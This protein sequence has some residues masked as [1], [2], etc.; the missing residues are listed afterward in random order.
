[1]TSPTFITVNPSDGNPPRS[2]LGHLIRYTI[3]DLF[4]RGDYSCTL[5]ADEPTILTGANGTG[6]S[7]IL[8]SINAIG[9]DRGN[10]FVRMPFKRIDLEFDVG[11]QL[12]VDRKNDALVVHLDGLSWAYEPKRLTPG[13]LRLSDIDLAVH[14]DAARAIEQEMAVEA[15]RRLVEASSEQNPETPAWA[16]S[17]PEQFPVLFITDQRLVREFTREPRSS[18]A[19]FTGREDPVPTRRAVDEFAKDLAQRISAAFSVYTQRSVELDRD[20]PL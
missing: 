8:R 17:I 5:A 1:M 19:R 6:K 15:Y 3:T 2:P 9:I 4:N 13:Q 11:S 7:T 14:L 16:A 10:D 18:R 20:F 12:T